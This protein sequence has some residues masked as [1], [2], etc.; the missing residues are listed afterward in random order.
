MCGIMSHRSTEL[1]SGF[2]KLSKLLRVVQGMQWYSTSPSFPRNE[3]AEA[4][5]FEN[6][7]MDDS[8]SSS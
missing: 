6:P 1:P 8:L 7:K 3:E 4:E 5:E 2:Q